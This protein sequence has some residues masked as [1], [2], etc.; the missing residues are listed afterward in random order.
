MKIVPVSALAVA[1]IL[2]AIAPNVM[3]SQGFW[4][5]SDSFVPRG[6][7]RYHLYVYGSYPSSTGEAIKIVN[8]HLKVCLDFSSD[9]K[10]YLCHRI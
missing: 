10:P 6:F 4:T 1:V 3:V 8:E 5:A 7:Q 9:Q 2:S